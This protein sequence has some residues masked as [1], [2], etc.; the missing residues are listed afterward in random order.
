MAPVGE[1]SA[2]SLPRTWV[3]YLVRE[4]RS[5][6]LHSVVKR[7]KKDLKVVLRYLKPSGRSVLPLSQGFRLLRSC[8]ETLGTTFLICEGGNCVLLE[9]L[10]MLARSVA[11]NS[12]VTRR[13]HETPQA[14][15]RSGLPSPAPGESSLPGDRTAGGL[16][17]STTVR[18]NK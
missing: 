1:D 18:T 6:K 8:F 16:F 3:Q 17:T 12:S 15:T 4:R 5:H 2:F 11:S 13:I 9:L 14:R 10:L 7:K